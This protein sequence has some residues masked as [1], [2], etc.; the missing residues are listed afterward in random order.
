MFQA[1]AFCPS[2]SHMYIYAIHKVASDFLQE[3]DIFLTT[4]T[5]YFT[6]WN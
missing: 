5:S 3:L 6:F 1:C 4:L 2:S